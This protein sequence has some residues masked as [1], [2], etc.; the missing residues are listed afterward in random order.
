MRELVRTNDPVLLS[1]IRALLDDAGVAYDV[2]DQH[3]SHVLFW[4]HTIQSRLMVASEQYD[5]AVFVMT[6]A[7][8]EDHI[9]E[10]D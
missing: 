6:N 10:P 5:R 9:H 8:L 3:T 4:L 7:G 2:F 1:F